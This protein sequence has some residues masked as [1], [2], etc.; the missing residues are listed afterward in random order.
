MKIDKY[1]R[2]NNCL[3]KVMWVKSIHTGYGNWQPITD[4]EGKL[5]VKEYMIESQKPIKVQLPTAVKNT[6]VDL[7]PVLPGNVLI[8]IM[9]FV[10][11]FL[12]LFIGVITVL[13]R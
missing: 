1:A 7:T 8:L 10:I 5:E 12:Q 11:V 3:G 6:E 2:V 4:T 9:L 13:R